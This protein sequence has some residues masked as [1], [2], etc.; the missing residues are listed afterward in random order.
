MLVFMSDIHLTD[1]TSGETINPGTFEKLVCTEKRGRV[2]PL[3]PYPPLQDSACGCSANDRRDHA[4]GLLQHWDME[5]N[6]CKDRL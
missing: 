6:T 4:E 2:C 3:R 1:G 5:E